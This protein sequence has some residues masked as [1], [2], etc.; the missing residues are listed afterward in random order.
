MELWDPDIALNFGKDTLRITVFE[1]GK[2][3]FFWKIPGMFSLISQEHQIEQ[4]ALLM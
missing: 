3:N 4:R 1:F 2:A